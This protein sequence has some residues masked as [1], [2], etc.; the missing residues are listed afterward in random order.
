MT[1]KKNDKPVIIINCK[2]YAQASGKQA[3]Q[4][5]R[6]ITSVIPKK[7]EILLSVQAPDIHACSK[8][9]VFILAQHIDSVP[10][11]GFTGKINVKSLIDNS[12]IGSLVNHSEDP[13][14]FK[15][16]SACVSILHQ[17]KLLS[18]VCVKNPRMARRVAKLA[19]DF[20]AIEPPKLIGGDVS[21]TNADPQI[22]LRTV[23]EVNKINPSIK[24]LCGAGV[25]TGDDTKKA[26]ELGCAGVLV[27]SGVTKADDQ[28]KAIEDLISKI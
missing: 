23:N 22:I 5:A 24:V 4:L 7:A 13:V 11:G 14:S 18:I 25:K 27:A 21:V 17:H 16:I 28:K 19:P 8:T 10:Q 1:I 15:E 2:T 12:A 26:L 20:I 9:G 6:S 3:V